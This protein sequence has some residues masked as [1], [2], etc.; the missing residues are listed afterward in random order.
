MTVL[1]ILAIIVGLF[2]IAIASKNVLRSID[3]NAD[4][5]FF[6]SL[7]LFFFGF[8]IIPI[9]LIYRLIRDRKRIK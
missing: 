1:I 8:I 9:G 6:N 7:I 5:D 2:N 3:E 4:I